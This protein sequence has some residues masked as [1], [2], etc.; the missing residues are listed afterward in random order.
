MQVQ[1]VALLSGLRIWCCHELWYR[2]AATVVQLLGLHTFSTTAWVQSLVWELRF[3]IQLL[4]APAK[5][6]TKQKKN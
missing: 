6:K 5:Q 1:S 2:P 3:H 4:Y